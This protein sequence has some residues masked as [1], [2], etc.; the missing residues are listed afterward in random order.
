MA[1]RIAI[2]PDRLGEHAAQG[3]YFLGGYV[4]HNAP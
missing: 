1:I 3:S 2:H 4:G